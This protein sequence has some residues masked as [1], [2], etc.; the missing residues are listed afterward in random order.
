M[1]EYSKRSVEL[2][3]LLREK[4]V[5]NIRAAGRVVEKDPITGRYVVLRREAS[6]A[7]S[8]ERSKTQ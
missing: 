4:A 2:A 6:S 1:A 8:V 7:S 3:A 5:A